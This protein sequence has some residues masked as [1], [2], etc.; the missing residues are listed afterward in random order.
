MSILYVRCNSILKNYRKK[1]IEYDPSLIKEESEIKLIKTLADY[2]NTIEDAASHYKPS[3]IAHYLIN[4]AQSFNEFYHSNQV[5]S[6]DKEL[7]KARI[8]LVEVTKQVLSNGL[9]LLAI[10]S[11]DEM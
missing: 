8:K 3:T 6:D 7:T 9:N 5:I 10:E 11:P 1:V 4:L 2:P